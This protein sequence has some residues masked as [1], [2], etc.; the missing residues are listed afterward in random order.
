LPKDPDI[1]EIIN[2]AGDPK[3]KKLFREIDDS[4][5]LLLIYRIVHYDEAIPD[6]D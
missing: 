5:K 1:S 6:K 4:R 2:D 3:C